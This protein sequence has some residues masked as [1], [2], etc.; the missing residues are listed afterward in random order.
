MSVSKVYNDFDMKSLFE[1]QKLSSKFQILLERNMFLDAPHSMGNDD[2]I[3]AFGDDMENIDNNH[4]NSTI[5]VHPPVELDVNLNPKPSESVNDNDKNEIKNMD[6]SLTRINEDEITLSLGVPSVLDF[7]EKMR[8]MVDTMNMALAEPPPVLDKIHSYRT[9][10]YLVLEFIPT[11]ELSD[12]CDKAVDDV[13]IQLKPQNRQILFR[14]S[15][16]AFLGR[17]IRRS[18]NAKVFESGLHALHCF[19]PDDPIRLSIILWRENTLNWLSNLTNEFNGIVDGDIDSTT[20]SLSTFDDY[21]TNDM[22]MDAKTQGEHLLSHINP[23]N[24]PVNASINGLMHLNIDN[25]PVEIVADGRADLC[26]L[27]LVEEIS[28][29]VGRDELFKRSLLLIRG[30]WTYEA[31]SYINEST[32]NLLSDTVLCILICSVFNQYHAEIHQPLQALSIFLCEYSDIKWDEVAVT[33]Q[34]AVP[35]HDIGGSEDQPCLRAPLA[36]DLITTSIL[37]KHCDVYHMCIRSPTPSFNNSF[38]SQITPEKDMMHTSKGENI[39]VNMITSSNEL[40]SNE[41]PPSLFALNYSQTIQDD[42]SEE[43]EKDTTKINPKAHSPISPITPQTVLFLP[44]KS[45]SQTPSLSTSPLLSPLLSPKIVVKD[46]NSALVSSPLLPPINSLHSLNLLPSMD[47]SL[48]EKFNDKMNDNLSDKSV[49]NFLRKSSLST[50]STAS[51]QTASLSTL[52]KSSLKTSD[53]SKSKNTS[54]TIINITSSNADTN[55]TK[56]SVNSN[57]SNMK[58]NYLIES[59]C[60]SPIAVRNF[61]KRQINIVHPLTNA[62]MITSTMTKEK[63]E[64]ISLAF[65]LSS[66]EMNTILTLSK[67]SKNSSNNSSS[68]NSTKDEKNDDKDNVKNSLNESLLKIAIKRFFKNIY[69]KFSSD[70][71][72]DII[73]NV[74]NNMKSINFD[75]TKNVYVDIENSKVNFETNGEGHNTDVEM[76]SDVPRY[77]CVDI[78]S[79]IFMFM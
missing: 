16:K 5:D 55:T 76:Y 26:F 71:L 23:I 33:L 72:P 22:D 21:S 52:A 34:G 60:Y 9:S 39:T 19:L 28:V 65:I 53:I 7:K 47:K 68:D 17:G 42:E 35:F 59:H 41:L 15:A 63:S 70:F 6:A 12:I 58:K 25:F 61:N 49:D 62:N 27:A 14:S 30:W 4:S 18:L 38:L 51:S 43:G 31:S 11:N 57:C 79:F 13:L 69:E 29:L 78:Y 56:N 10:K 67:N 37:Q 54:T 77:V 2:L 75:N 44:P 73:S 20:P 40:P 46:I 48:L 3:P 8:R 74:N 1:E 24:N 45:T 36:S 32:K 50:C 64:K 66:I